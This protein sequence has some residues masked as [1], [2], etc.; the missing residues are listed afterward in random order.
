MG[1]PVPRDSAPETNLKVLDVEA[2]LR[3]SLAKWNSERQQLFGQLIQS[4]KNGD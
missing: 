1:R 2:Q 3:D 4:R